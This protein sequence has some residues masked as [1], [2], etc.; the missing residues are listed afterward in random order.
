MGAGGA[1]RWLRASLGPV[2]QPPTVSRC[3]DVPSDPEEVLRPWAAHEVRAC[4][5]PAA[6]S[7]PVIH[8]FVRTPP[9]PWPL[10]RFVGCSSGNNLRERLRWWPRPRLKTAD[11]CELGVDGF[12]GAW[13]GHGTSMP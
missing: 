4:S 5:H 3:G 13:T 9:T 6:G 12:T 11:C 7:S 10:P 1:G 8:T 2:F